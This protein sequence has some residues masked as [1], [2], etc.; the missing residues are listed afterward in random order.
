[1]EHAIRTL[2]L[3][4]HEQARRRVE[5]C[6]GNAG[7]RVGPTRTGRQDRRA[8][9]VRRLAVHLGA[10]R[11]RLLVRVADRVERALARERL[12][13][14]HGAAAGHQEDVLDALLRDEADDVV[15]KFRHLSW[16]LAARTGPRR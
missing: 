2:Y 5:P 11:A 4:R 14:M 7:D 15:G 8:E 13:E 6:P 10:N 9:I 3:T 16:P 12:V 1:I